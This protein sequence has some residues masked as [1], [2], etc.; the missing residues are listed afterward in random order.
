TVSAFGNTATPLFVYAAVCTKVMSEMATIGRDARRE[1][2]RCELVAEG[3]G[4]V[5]Y[6]FDKRVNVSQL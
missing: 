6:Q 3:F 4:H 2:N 1:G 5:D